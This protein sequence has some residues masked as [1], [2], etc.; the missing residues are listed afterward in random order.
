M[1]NGND[2]NV[3][4]L[5]VSLR[6][7]MA[8][9]YQGDE[10]N[11]RWCLVGR[12]PDSSSSWQFG[13]EQ[14]FLRV[15][16][17]VKPQKNRKLGPAFDPSFDP[18]RDVLSDFPSIAAARLGGTV[19]EFNRL[20]SVQLAVCNLRCWHCYVEDCLVWPCEGCP[21]V[22]T[23]GCEH[24]RLSG[25]TYLTA[26]NI[27]DAIRK[28]IECD[29]ANGQGARHAV[30]LTGGEPLLAP[31]LILMLLRGIRERGYERNVWFR[32]E[33]NLVPLL[34]LEAVG[35]KD[36]YPHRSDG[37]KLATIL[38]SL[39]QFRNLSV[40][41]AFHGLSEH[42]FTANTQVRLPCFDLLI[43]ALRSLIARGI[44]VYPS[45]GGNV[46]D[47][48]EIP[49]FFERLRGISKNLPLRVALRRYDLG[50][51]PIA[52]RIA[53][54]RKSKTPP[55]TFDY[56]QSIDAW[57]A[58]IIKAYGRRYAQTPRWRVCL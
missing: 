28:Q 36:S 38:D 55:I 58:L 14:P 47:P 26:T 43:N 10:H 57:D 25:I 1:V 8:I 41:P 16:Q 52:R 19:D 3:Q 49:A 6:H 17:P 40:H 50:Y 13:V 54:L 51:K 32:C 35:D 12:F 7:H 5:L 4:A 46:C 48:A 27:L 11:A 29:R 45:F 30:R 9:S 39:A 2:L 20:L 22:E 56:G 34:L 44:D 24:G 42:G 23:P 15:F 37:G 31:Q 18:H 53:Q 21:R 33:T